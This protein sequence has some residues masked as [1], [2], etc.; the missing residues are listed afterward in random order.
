M[1]HSTDHGGNIFAV[2]RELGVGHE[3]IVDF[4]ASINPLGISAAV[5]DAMTRSLD[6]L[7]HYPDS[8]HLELKRALA[9]HHGLAAEQF[10]IANGSTEII[11]NLP[12]LLDGS[13]ALLVSPSFSEYGK[14]LEQHRWQ[15]RQMVLN[16]AA[17]FAIDLELLER[18]LGEGIDLLVIC[19]P[20]N[21]SGMLH[22]EEVI[23]RVC[24]LCHSSGTFL[25]LDEAFMDFCEYASAKRLLVQYDKALVL[26][27]MTKFFAIPGLRLGY[28]ISNAPLAERLHALGGPWRV[29]TLA[30][31]AGVAALHDHVHNRESAAFVIRERKRLF[32]GLASIGP[33]RPFPSHANYLLVEMTG[34]MNA[35]Q[36]KEQLLPYRILIRD[37]GTFAGLT[38]HF[39]RV[40]VRSETEN[41]RLLECLKLILK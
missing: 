24:S 25:L 36:L 11:H 20:G 17:G 38:P 32:E 12:L 35:A 18:K 33:L 1:P 31:E 5:R 26:R 9:E 28:A 21:P 10:T 15:V 4:S 39:F 7:V 13:Q 40:A 29:N 14:S 8:D 34:A 6:R 23:D 16:P 41:E 2:A 27:S 3:Q 37:C 30:L 22:P 19:N